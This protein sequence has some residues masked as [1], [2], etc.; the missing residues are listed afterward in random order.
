MSEFKPKQVFRDPL[1]DE[2]KVGTQD[3]LNE[4]QQFS[5]QEK[6][7]PKPLPEPEQES[8]SDEL[9]LAHIIRPAKTRRY[10]GGGLLV[11]FTAL[12]G[13]QTLDTAWQALQN[14]DWLQIGWVGFSATLAGL[15]IAALGRELWKLR[16][17]RGRLDMQTQ[18]QAVI[19]SDSVGKG[20]EF[21]AHLA[22]QSHIHENNTGLKR[23]AQALNDA[24]SDAEVLEMYDA[25]VVAQQDKLATKIVTKH[26]TESAAL[27]AVSPLAAADML[28]VASRN[29]QMINSIA[30]VYGMELGYWSRLR[31]FKLVLI[32]MAAAG[33]SEVAID[34]SVDLMS[35]DLAG[36]MSA[37]VGQGIGVGLLTARLGIKA[38]SLLRPLPWQ[39]GKAIKLSSI[40]KVLLNKVLSL[41]AKQ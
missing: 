28:L 14:G 7:V 30:T 23:W 40:R 22:K 10:W 17:L 21:C 6:F 11:G 37:R 3:L 2:S 36:R 39:E 19:E 33:A 34:A 9:E 29:L 16:A 1:V 13:W 4:A 8:Q 25:M 15:G 41:T 12:V 5:N 26:A 38:I 18:A 27:I 35:V 24:H 20:R 32:N 31:L